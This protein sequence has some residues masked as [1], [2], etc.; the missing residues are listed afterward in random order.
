MSWSRYR[1]TSSAVIPSRA[2]RATCSTSCDES[3]AFDSGKTYRLPGG[4][5]RFE[6]RTRP[7]KRAPTSKREGAERDQEGSQRQDCHR[8]EWQ[9]DRLTEQ[10]RNGGGDRGH[11]GAEHPG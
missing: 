1:T 11:D 10:R 8:P 6:A 2:S 9:P 4:K 7:S 5:P 3:S